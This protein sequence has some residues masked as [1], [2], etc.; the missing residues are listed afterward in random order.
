LNVLHVFVLSLH[1]QFMFAH[2]KRNKLNKYI[3]Q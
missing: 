2:V 1:T 3:L